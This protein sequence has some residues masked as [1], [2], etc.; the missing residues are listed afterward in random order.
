MSASTPTRSP[1]LASAPKP[2]WLLWAA[3][4]TRAMAIVFVVA[5]LGLGSA[6]GLNGT[7]LVGW[8]AAGARA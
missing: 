6:L 2:L 3:S 1:R 8:H 5:L 7:G 4:P